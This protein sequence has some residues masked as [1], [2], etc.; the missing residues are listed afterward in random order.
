M[1]KTEHYFFIVFISWEYENG[2]YTKLKRKEEKFQ[3]QSSL[4]H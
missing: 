4:K 3:K 2:L 1:K